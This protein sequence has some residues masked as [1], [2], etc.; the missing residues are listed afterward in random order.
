MA[1]FDDARDALARTV[2]R[3]FPYAKPV[4][5][6]RGVDAW[7]APRPE[8]AVVGASTGTYDPKVIVVGIAD[9]KSGPVVYFLDPGDYHALDTHRA[10]LEDAGLKVGRGCI[11]HTKKGPLPVAALEKLFRLTKAR[12]AKAGKPRN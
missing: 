12:D 10:L 5:Q 6:W 9:R 7:A 2:R 11:Y 1:D 4:E 3:V 8:A